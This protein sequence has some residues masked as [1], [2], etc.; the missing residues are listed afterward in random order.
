MLNGGEFNES[1]RA[2]RQSAGG[3]GVPRTSM[4]VTKLQREAIATAARLRAISRR[5]KAVAKFVGY[6]S[7]SDR[8][9]SLAAKYQEQARRLEECAGLHTNGVDPDDRPSLR[10]RRRRRGPHK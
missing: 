1:Y 8:L 9:N 5:C 7:V 4:A 2:D 6:R 3:R 10:L